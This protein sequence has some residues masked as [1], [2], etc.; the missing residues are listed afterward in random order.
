MREFCPDVLQWL[1][2][3]LASLAIAISCENLPLS[4]LIVIPTYVEHMNR[5]ETKADLVRV[6]T[7]NDPKLAQ[8]GLEPLPFSLTPD[9]D[10]VMLIHAI[11]S[12]WGM[13]HLRSKEFV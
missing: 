12:A 4:S 9:D 2:H 10:V 7:S 1:D 6:V 5:I 8:L 3:V 13:G 11:V